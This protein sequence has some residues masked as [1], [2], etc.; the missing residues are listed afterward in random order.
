MDEIN[1]LITESGWPVRM[2]STLNDTSS[3]TDQAYYQNFE[4]SFQ[5][6]QDLKMSLVLS[7]IT[8]INE[9]YKDKRLRPDLLENTIN[10]PDVAINGHTSN[11]KCYNIYANDDLVAGDLDEEQ[12]YR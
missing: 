8:N 2:S 10:Q 7:P 3:S 5:D 6:V 9:S 12:N 1:C 4:E 11:H